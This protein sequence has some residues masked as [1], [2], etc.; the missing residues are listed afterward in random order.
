MPLYQIT[1]ELPAEAVP[2]TPIHI[3]AILE[4]KNNHIKVLEVVKIN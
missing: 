1:I 2:A 4:N 3:E